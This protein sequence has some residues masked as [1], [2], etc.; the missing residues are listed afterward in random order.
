[1]PSAHSHPSKSPHAPTRE[2]HSVTG[3]VGR[4]FALLHRAC[5]IDARHMRPA[6]HKPAAAVNHEAVFVIDSSVFD[7]NGNVASRQ[8]RVVKFADGRGY[9]STCLF[10][11]KCSEHAR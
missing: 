8:Q 6:L 1:M 3:L 2:D 7:R 9:D 10:Q 11:D 5:E 4:V